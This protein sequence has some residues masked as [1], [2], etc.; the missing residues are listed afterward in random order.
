MD[1]K[2]ENPRDD[3]DQKNKLKTSNSVKDVKTLLKELEKAPNPEQKQ[4]IEQQ[5]VAVTQVRMS[6]RESLF[7]GP[8]PS[9]DQFLKY[10]QVLPGAADRILTMAEKQMAHRQSIED[11]VVVSNTRNSMMGV[12]SAFI[13]ALTAICGGIYLAVIGHS[14]GTLLSL[15]GLGSLIYVFIYGTRSSRKEREEKS[16]TSQK[17]K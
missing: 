8:L 14:Y 11:K 6:V 4:E 3:N 12:I 17:D 10:N 15:T 1:I 5:I 13:L 2:P 16:K 7:S 9:P